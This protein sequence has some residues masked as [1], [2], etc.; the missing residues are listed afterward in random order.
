MTRAIAHIAGFL[1]VLGMLVGVLGAS[2]ALASSEEDEA[3]GSVYT[4]TN[5]AS[6]NSVLVFER[7]ENG[8]LT[9][10]GRF[11]TGGNGNGAGLGSQG[12]LTLSKDRHWLFAVNAGSN[13]ISAFAVKHEGLALKDRVSSGGTQP[14][15]VATRGDLVYVL[16]AGGT[17]SVSGFRLRDG[18]LRPIAGST[19]TLSGAGP[20]EVAISRA[21]HVLVV[22]DKGT[23]TIETF[24]LDERGAAGPSVSHPSH[25]RTPFGFAFGRDGQV[26]VSEAAGGPGNLSATSSYVVGNNGSLTLV[27]GSVSTTQLAACWVVVTKNGRFAYTANTAS[28]SI[29]TY[30]IDKRG[31]ITLQAAVAAKAD[32]SHPTDMALSRGSQFL[33]VLESGTSSIGAYQAKAD[34]GLTA[35][36][37]V[38]GLPAG[39]VG[40]AA[41]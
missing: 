26:F 18:H 33:Y 40:L 6:G 2:P 29:S 28:D 20:A 23:D 8:R 31:A 39:S 21:G 32:R 38:S 7:A 9:A 12:A 27:S 35:I 15:S 16:N 25:G 1:A 36:Q 41:R 4:L 34:G 10:S 30:S 24:V 17:P 11:A 5:A 3:D 14:I 37:R 13:D 22:T 19:R